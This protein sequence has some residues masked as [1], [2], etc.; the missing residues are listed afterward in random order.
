M[1][2]AKTWRYSKDAGIVICH[3]EC[4]NRQDCPAPNGNKCKAEWEKEQAAI[5]AERDEANGPYITEID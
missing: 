2:M 4:F 1:T 5:Q 3:F